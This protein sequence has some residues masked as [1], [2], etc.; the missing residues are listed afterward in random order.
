VQ[1]VLRLVEIYFSTFPVFNRLF[2]PTFQLFSCQE[3]RETQ[4]QVR[5]SDGAASVF[6]TV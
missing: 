3:V 6:G 4:I 2:F 1:K 5:T